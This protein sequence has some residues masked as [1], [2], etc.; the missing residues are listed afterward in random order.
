MKNGFQSRQNSNTEK[1]CCENSRKRKFF[2]H[3]VEIMSLETFYNVAWETN[4][5]LEKVCLLSGFL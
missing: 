1:N 4:L 2:E 5:L 3:D